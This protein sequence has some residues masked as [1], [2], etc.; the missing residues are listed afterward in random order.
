MK[1]KEVEVPKNVAGY[2]NL[3]IKVQKTERNEKKKIH[4]NV[5]GYGNIKKSLQ[6]RGR[7]QKNQKQSS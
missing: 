6:K 7:F 1:K 3:R 4:Q 2:G 5:A